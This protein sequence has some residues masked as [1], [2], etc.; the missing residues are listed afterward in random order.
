ML[1]PYAIVLFIPKSDATSQSCQPIATYY[2]SIW[3]NHAYASVN[4]FFRSCDLCSGRTRPNTRTYASAS[5]ITSF[6]YM[7]LSIIPFYYTYYHSV[8]TNHAKASVNG[9]FRSCPLLQTHT[10]VRV[11]FSGYK[12]LIHAAIDNPFLLHI[13]IYYT[14]YYI[15]FYILYI[16][17]LDI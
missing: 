13:F 8:W 3:T 7:P 6:W 5:P 15:L 12:L 17:S 14:I 16:N 10:Y 11:G 2:H 4:G 9:F 1:A